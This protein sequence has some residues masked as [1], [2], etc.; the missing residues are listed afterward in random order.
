MTAVAARLLAWFDTHGRHDLPWQEARTPYSVWVAEIMLQQTQVGTV[1]PF[2]RRFL[3]RFP[4]GKGA[5]RFPAAV[6]AGRISTASA[7]K[8]GK[9]PCQT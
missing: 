2:Y 3:R 6:S 5:S 7:R 9:C 8:A 4:T 1:V